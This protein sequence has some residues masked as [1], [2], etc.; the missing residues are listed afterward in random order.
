MTEQDFKGLIESKLH[1][2]HVFVTDLQGTGDHFEAVVIAPQFKGKSR[3][4]QHRLVY[5]AC[6]DHLTKEIHALKLQTHSPD[7]WK[8][9]PKNNARLA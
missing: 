8:K 3:L 5:D 9:D 6:G 7:E 2:A 4:N 1:G